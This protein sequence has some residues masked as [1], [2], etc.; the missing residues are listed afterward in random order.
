LL[1]NTTVRTMYQTLP[2]VSEQPHM[3]SGE[4]GE[5]G[6]EEKEQE[7]STLYETPVH[8]TVAPQ[9]SIQAVDERVPTKPSPSMLP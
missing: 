8:S 1:S 5:E 7:M 9:A 4:Q 6:A 2:D 3:V